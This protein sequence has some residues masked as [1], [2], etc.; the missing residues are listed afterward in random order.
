MS[1]NCNN[2]CNSCGRNSCNSCGCRPSCCGCNAGNTN[3][4]IETMCTYSRYVDVPMSIYY[5]AGYSDL[6]CCE[7]TKNVLEQISDSLARMSACFNCG[8][9]DGDNSNNNNGC[10]CNG[11]NSCNSCG[12]RRWR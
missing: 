7:D 8:E 2:N 1:C 6:N 5:G 9:A 11:C 4:E 12:C 10:G 3:V